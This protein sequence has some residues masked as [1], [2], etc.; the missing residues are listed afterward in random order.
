[1]LHLLSLS[2]YGHNCVCVSAFM[3]VSLWV[4]VRVHGG[5]AHICVD[6]LMVFALTSLQNYTL[7][8]ML[9]LRCALNSE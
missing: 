4:C 2:L 5:C 1:M 8:F 9:M 6:I 7:K 3:L